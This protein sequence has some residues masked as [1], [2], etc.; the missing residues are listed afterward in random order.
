MVYKDISDII[1][2]QE[3]LSKALDKAELLNEKLRVVGSLTRH[4][5]CNKLMATKSNV[6]L[7]KKR[8]GDN[9]DLVKYLDSIDSALA[10]SGGIFEFSR[11][12]EK[13]GSEKPSHEN[14][15]ECFNQASNL[16]PNLGNVKVFN[17]CQGLEVVAD[18]LLKQL[19]YN[20]IDNSLKHGEK[21]T[22]IWL[23]CVEDADRVKLFYEDNGVG[24]PKA[25]KQKL[26]QKGFTT[27]KS[28]GL[29]LF[30]IKK[31]G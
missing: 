13:V 6:Y 4:D 20:F 15:F 28:T 26:F 21:V 24:I 9:T 12:Y 3:E 17:E 16:M 11:L 29:G 23:H 30:L 1:T 2:V 31:N 10:L 27:G 7:L 19:F 22:Q 25:N 5:I 14:V 18:S 8:I